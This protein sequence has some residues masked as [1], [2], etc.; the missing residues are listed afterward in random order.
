[1][2]GEKIRKEHTG[3]IS[4]YLFMIAASVVL[5][6]LLLGSVQEDFVLSP[7]RILDLYKSF[8]RGEF[9]R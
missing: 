2:L 9:I 4:H 3:K 1:M 6:F 5:L 7:S 8:P